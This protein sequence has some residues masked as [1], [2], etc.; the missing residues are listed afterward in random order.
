MAAQVYFIGAGPG[1][2]DLITVK[3]KKIIDRAEVIIYADSL[4]NPGVYAD[5]RPDAK[6]YGSAHLT[7]EEIMTL[8]IGAVNDGKI[9]ARLQTGD[10]SVYGAIYEQMAVLDEKGIEYEIIPGV[11]SMFAAIAALKAEFTVPELSQTLIV[12]RIEGKT[13]VPEPERLQSLAAHHTSMAVFLSTSMAEKVSSELIA[14]GYAPDTP[15]AVVYRASWPDQEILRTTVENLAHDIKQAGL[16]RQT[17]I[18]VG[19]FLRDA[20]PERRSKLYSGKFAHGYRK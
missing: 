8:I 13:P 4:V 5:A 18:L 1:D 10:P 9:V 15:A 11:S 17:L 2:P 19:N 6:V 16:T 3:A 7:L 20:D 14:G 12:T